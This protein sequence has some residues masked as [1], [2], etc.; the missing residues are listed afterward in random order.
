M[1]DFGADSERRIRENAVNPELVAAAESF[2]LPSIN[3]K[4]SYNFYWMG[5]PIIQYPTDI[6]RIQQLIWDVKPDL[7]IET[8][9]A[10]GGSLILS[11]SI[12]ELAAL[13]GG[14]GDARVLGID[15]DIRAHN[16]E[17]ILDH[18]MSRR[19]TM[20]EGSSTDPN[21]VAQVNEH[22]RNSRR[23]MVFLDSNHTHEHVLREL[24]LYAPLVSKGSYCV[25]F[26][27]IVEMLPMGTVD[28]RPW[29]KGDNP[30]TAVDQ[31]LRS[32]P[33]FV[34]DDQIDGQLLIS[35]AP[36]GYLRRVS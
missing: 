3:A 5:R 18:P 30:M 29:D 15:I 16:R 22:A 27:T 26:D 4:Y 2:L 13:D 31:Y 33:N 9:I 34:V 11:A 36:R 12:L 35:A 32:N 8:G 25:V 21:I 19:I 6:V 14:A 17:A 7:I 20:I 28:D 10:H 23:T 1:E 24:E